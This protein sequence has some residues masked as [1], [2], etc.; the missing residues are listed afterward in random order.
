MSAIYIQLLDTPQVFYNNKPVVFPFKKAEALFYYIAV[1][2]KVTKEQAALL[3]WCDSEE[4]TSKGSLRNALYS[5]KKCFEPEDIFSPNSHHLSLREDLDIKIDYHEFINNNQVDL[6]GNGFLNGFI[7]KNADPFQEWTSAKQLYINEQYCSMLYKLMLNTPFDDVSCTEKY[8]Y[9]YLKIDPLDERPYIIMMEVYKKNHLFYKGIKLYRQL[10][11][12]LNK[13]LCISPCQEARELN[14]FLL[15]HLSEDVSIVR[16]NDEDILCR[17]KEYGILSS[18]FQAFLSG[19][20]FSSV[21]ISGEAG[22]G[23]TYLMESFIDRIDPASCYVL[24]THCFQAEEGMTL[25]PWTAM[26]T[27]LDRYCS[28]N[29][30]VLDKAC[31]KNISAFFPMICAPTQPHRLPEDIAVSYN[32]RTTRNS[33]LKILSDAAQYSPIVLAI[34]ALEYM[35]KASLEILSFLIRARDPNIF[36]IGTCTDAADNANNELLKSYVR[37]NFITRIPLKC[38]SRA[39]VETILSSSLKCDQADTNLVD[40]VYEATRGNTFHLYTILNNIDGGNAVKAIDINVKD[41]LIKRLATIPPG[42]RQLLDIISLFPNHAPLPVLEAIFSRDS[43]ELVNSLDILKQEDLISEKTMDD[44][45]ILKFKYNKI[46]E[47]IHS[48]LPASKLHVLHR[49]V[50]SCIER[51]PYRSEG[52]LCHQL[53]YHYS[54]CRDEY[55]VL[56]YKLKQLE[57]YSSISFELYPVL[58]HNAVPFEQKSDDFMQHINELEAALSRLYKS[59]AYGVEILD[60]NARLQQIKGKYCI[61]QCY[62][63]KGLEAINHSITCDSHINKTPLFQICSQRIIIFYAIQVYDTN[64]MKNAL[65]RILKLEKDNGLNDEYAIDCRLLGLY[66]SMVGIYDK[67]THFLNLSITLLKSTPI[68]EEG[69]ALNIAACYNYLGEVERKQQHFKEALSYYQKSFT[70]CSTWNCPDN[71]TFYTNMGRALLAHGEKESAVKAFEKA[72]QLYDGSSILVGRSI[73]KA[74]YAL[75]L[76]EKGN[77]ALARKLINEAEDFSRMLS[78]P[79]ESGITT[80]VMANLASDFPSFNRERLGEL[81]RKAH[82]YLKDIP[83]IYELSS[84]PTDIRMS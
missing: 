26:L 21:L 68:K 52:Q 5:I 6:Y 55:K 18:L 56:Y 2:K 11:A 9:R 34:D 84:L 47:M 67:A 72:N 10:A 59:P 41:I 19:H 82:S 1:E 40:E 14:D 71:A 79:V 12:T 63:K 33:I 53:I 22:S 73:A 49:T 38:F 31:V 76:A 3:L 80:I 16:S 77:T 61:L 7:V 74:Y 81:C 62:Y 43:L 70:I 48:L 8:F 83:G 17:G 75:L 27:Q 15:K 37:L 57:I 66:Y 4:K 51:L 50:A 32:Y 25:Q 78:S 58:N 24:H 60:M 69:L 64:L 29:S 42:A 20:P 28:Q 13:E 46:Q 39:Q 54:M 30:I 36:I 35:D 65:D 23:K 45:I 44:E